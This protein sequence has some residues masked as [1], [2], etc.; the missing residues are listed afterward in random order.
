MPA[1]PRHVAAIC[2][3]ICFRTCLLLGVVFASQVVKAQ[4]QEPGQPEKTTLASGIQRVV[5]VDAKSHIRYVRL[6]LAGTLRTPSAAISTDQATPEPA[7]PALIAQCTLRPNGRSVFELFAT[8]NGVP[9]M[10]F[11][12]PWTPASQQ[13]LF[14]PPTAKVTM[15]ME[16]LGYTHVKPVRRQ[17]EIPVQ[18]PDQYRYNSPGGGSSNMEEISFHLRYLLA[19]PTLRLTLANRSAEFLTTPLLD[20]IRKEPL[21]RAAGL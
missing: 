19:L 16:F 10:T 15:T 6:A 3:A 4:E 11:Y 14:A 13:D 21:C 1:R 5:G 8:F 2:I 9:D 7:A 17:W 12:P 18:T 20:E